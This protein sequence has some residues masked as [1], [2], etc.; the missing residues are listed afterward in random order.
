MTLRSGDN[1]DV[2]L[3]RVVQH[4]EK[5]LGPETSWPT[6]VLLESLAQ[7]VMNSIYSTGNRS[8]SVVRVLDR[9]RKRR[10]E[11]GHDPALDG[12]AELLAEIDACGG[13]DGFSDA[14]DNRWRAWSRKTAP[15]KT[16]VIQQA[17]QLLLEESVGTR[18]EL[19]VALEKP[20][21]QDALKRGWLGLPG[22]RS[23]LT[24][25]YF[26]M[27]AGLPGI[28]ADRMIT[29]WMTRTLGRSTTPAEAERLL[30]NAADLLGVHARHLDH[31][32]WVRERQRS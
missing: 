8:E 4:I 7:C 5:D 3:A 30:L 21:T 32:L 22:Q 26:L 12:P 14:L 25:R 17:A 1:G 31:A 24:W 16:Q 23:G 27:N 2:N 18:E 20:T 28:K 19:E 10:R 29:R 11:A 15:L 9:Y 13:P 6:P